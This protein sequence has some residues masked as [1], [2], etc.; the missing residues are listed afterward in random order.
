MSQDLV[1]AALWLNMQPARKLV[2]IALCERAELNTGKCWPGLEEISRRSS[3]SIR[4]VIPHI[5]GLEADGWIRSGGRPNRQGVTTRRWVNVRRLLTEGEA[6]REAFLSER[7]DAHEDSSTADFANDPQLKLDAPAHEVDGNQHMKL[8]S[9]A[10]EAASRG[11]VI[12]PSQEPSQEPSPSPD[13][14]EP[15]DLSADDARFAQVLS[16]Q[17]K[18]LAIMPPM[19]VTLDAATARVKIRE[20]DLSEPLSKALGAAAKACGR[21]LRVELEGAA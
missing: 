14:F 13:G 1:T 9:P 21:E 19:A 20:Q 7:A 8:M 6:N 2:F 3:L 10:H 5:R 12:E 16:M 18:A 4:S 11:T 15:V 17:T